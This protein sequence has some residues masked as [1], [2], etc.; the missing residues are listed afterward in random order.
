[1]SKEK[2][3]KLVNSRRSTSN[4]LSINDLRE[5]EYN[6]ISLTKKEQVAIT[7]YESYRLTELNKHLNDDSFNKVYQ[8]LQVMANL[9]HWE[10]FLNDQYNNIQ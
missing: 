10:E 4:L 5:K 2:I 1:M 6:G 8:S 9:T 7:N 3:N